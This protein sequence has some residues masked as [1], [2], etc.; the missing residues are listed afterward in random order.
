MMIE[1]IIIAQNNLKIKQNFGLDISS[2]SLNAGNMCLDVFEYYAVLIIFFYFYNKKKIRE[3][4]YSFFS[5]FA[6][7]DF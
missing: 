4:N 6:F 3:E 7:H 2:F 1:F 5:R